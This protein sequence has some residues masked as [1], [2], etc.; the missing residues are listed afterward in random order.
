MHTNAPQKRSEASD[1]SRG[2]VNAIVGSLAPMNNMVHPTYLSNSKEY[3]IV[4]GVDI[5]GDQGL[6]LGI[7]CL[8]YRMQ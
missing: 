5:E 3:L 7:S 6:T 8:L 4:T 2:K 1:T